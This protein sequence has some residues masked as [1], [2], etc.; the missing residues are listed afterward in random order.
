V[1]SHVGSALAPYLLAFAGPAAAAVVI[2]V[3]ALTAVRDGDGVHLL[4]GRKRRSGLPWVL[5]GYCG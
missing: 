3:A 5:L 2:G 1:A 4:L